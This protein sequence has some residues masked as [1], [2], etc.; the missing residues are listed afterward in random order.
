[1]SVMWRWIAEKLLQLGSKPGWID[2]VRTS[3]V[4]WVVPSRVLIGVLLLFPAGGG[5]HWLFAFRGADNFPDVPVGVLATCML[6]RAVEIVAGISFVAGLGLRLAAYPALVIFAL[7]ALANTANSSAW[8]RDSVGA[9]IAPQGDWVIGAMYVSTIVLVSDLLHT[10]SG[11]WSV[12][13]WLSQSVETAGK[14]GGE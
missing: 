8:L 7:R 12:D 10:G 9:V 3:G 2:L 4:R 1:M 11:R 14:S 5:L 6:L 13:Y